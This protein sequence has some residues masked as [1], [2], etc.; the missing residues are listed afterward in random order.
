MHDG[1]GVLHDILG[2]VDASDEL[3]GQQ[4]AAPDV[5][6]HEDGE[7][8]VVATC[9]RSEQF[10]IRA[11]VIVHAWRARLRQAAWFVALRRSRHHSALLVSVKRSS[12]LG[13]AMV[14][15]IVAFA[16]AC[17]FTIA[18]AGHATPEMSCVQRTVSAVTG[19]I[20]CAPPSVSGADAVARR[21]AA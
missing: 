20:W 10:G 14:P 19:I 18:V 15:S 2:I 9:R 6:T 12:R 13:Q 16:V 3:D 8:A 17:E 21:S 7:S 4:G 1:E 11:R 5:A